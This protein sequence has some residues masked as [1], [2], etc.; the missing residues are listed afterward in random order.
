MIIRK[1]MKKDDVENGNIN[2]NPTKLTG[3]L[4]Y[5]SKLDKISRVVFPL[6]FALFN[7]IYWIVNLNFS[8]N[9]LD[10]FNLLTK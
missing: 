2:S 4:E 5:A 10:G 1:K 6:S 9:S 8:V 3:F 7:L